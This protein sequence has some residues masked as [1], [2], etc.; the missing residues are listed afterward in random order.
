MTS[1][2]RLP[3]ARRVTTQ[4]YGGVTCLAEARSGFEPLYEEN[5]GGDGDDAEPRPVEAPKLN[6]HLRAVLERVKRH[7]RERVDGR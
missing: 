6:P 5:S 3:S 4:T 7:E 1:S 2:E